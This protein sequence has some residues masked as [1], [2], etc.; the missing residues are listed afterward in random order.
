ME[1]S[2][3]ANPSFS[4]LALPFC[5]HL[6]E[7]HR[8]RSDHHLCLRL[9]LCINPTMV[10]WQV[11][12]SK[13]TQYQR[14]PLQMLHWATNFLSNSTLDLQL[15]SFYC[16]LFILTGHMSLTDVKPF[17]SSMKLNT[18]RKRWAMVWPLVQRLGQ[19]LSASPLTHF[20]FFFFFFFFAFQS[21]VSWMSEHIYLGNVCIESVLPK[22]RR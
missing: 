9:P 18:L 17:Y 19:H 15:S 14:Y 4:V 10:G 20:F 11:N 13:Q 2:A 6:S 12:P 5:S 7:I 8:K 21:V 1:V 3:T 22:G 16:C